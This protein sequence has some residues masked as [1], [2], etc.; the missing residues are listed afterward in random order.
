[1]AILGDLEVHAGWPT[2]QQALSSQMFPR[3]SLLAFA[4]K[5]LI[6]NTL[7]TQSGSSVDESMNVP[8]FLPLSTVLIYASV[9]FVLST[10]WPHISWLWTWF[11][12]RGLNLLAPPQFGCPLMA[13]GRLICPTTHSCLGPHQPGQ[14][15]ALLS[16]GFGIQTKHMVFAHDLAVFIYVFK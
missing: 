14:A 2:S 7:L 16:G 15:L 11:P 3:P 12:E 13:Y 6:L 5:S 10:L 8:G 4:P 9:S 1:M